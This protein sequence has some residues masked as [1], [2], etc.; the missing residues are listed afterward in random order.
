MEYFIALFVDIPSFLKEKLKEFMSADLS[1]AWL[2]SDRYESPL[3]SLEKLPSYKRR[4]EDF[5]YIHGSPRIETSV[6]NCPGIPMRW[7]V[8]I[9]DRISLGKIDEALHWFASSYFWSVLPWAGPD[10]FLS[11]AFLS[12]SCELRDRF[13]DVGS[14]YRTKMTLYFKYNNKGDY[15]EV[16]SYPEPD[17]SSSHNLYDVHL[18]I[19]N[20]HVK[21]KF[22]EVLQAIFFQGDIIRSK[23]KESAASR[24]WDACECDLRPPLTIAPGSEEDKDDYKEFRN[25]MSPWIETDYQFIRSLA[26]KLIGDPDHPIPEHWEPLSLGVYQIPDRASFM[27]MCNIQ[28]CDPDI[29]LVVPHETD[30][31]KLKSLL[32]KTESRL[33]YSYF[34]YIQDFLNLTDWFYVL[35][36]SKRDYVDSS[37]FV[38]RNNSILRKIDEFNR[39]DGYRLISCF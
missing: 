20:Y 27:S 26:I 9:R 36:V 30:L 12:T 23:K 15:P 1:E 10:S 14:N 2:V 3:I 37:L 6:Q 22:S 29:L 39:D 38:S 16:Y 33:E 5:W 11:F 34:C 4:H 35:D 18:L 24:I 28:L 7:N 32:T 17:Y 13:V 31:E 25:I 8:A 19:C 21:N